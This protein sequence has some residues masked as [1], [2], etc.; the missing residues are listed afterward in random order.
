MNRSTKIENEIAI[1]YSKRKTISLSVGKHGEIIVRAPKRCAKSTIMQ[2]VN[3]HEEWIARQRQRNAE[4]LLSPIHADLSDEEI[5]RLKKAARKYIPDRVK[6]YAPIV[7]VSVNRIAIR[8]Q[9]TKWGSCSAKGNLNFNCR[10]MLLT[11]D[12]IDY[13]VVHELCHRLQMNHSKLFWAEVERVIPNY[14]ELRKKL[15]S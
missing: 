15:N 14:K 9:S 12:L 5:D 6:Y 13:V 11:P 1:Y 7:G 10:L 8:N 2:F 4:R 3:E